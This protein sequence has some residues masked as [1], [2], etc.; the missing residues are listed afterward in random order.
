[1]T[2]IF[3]ETAYGTAEYPDRKA[4]LKALRVVGLKVK[5][6]RFVNEVAWGD[7]IHQAFSYL[8]TSFRYNAEAA[9]V[10]GGTQ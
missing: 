2:M 10:I 5:A 3:I 9:R 1:M 7:E 8:P 4:L 6:L